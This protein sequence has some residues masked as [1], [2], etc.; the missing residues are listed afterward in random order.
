M[1]QVQN[2][3]KNLNFLELNLAKIYIMLCETIVLQANLEN[4]YEFHRKDAKTTF[5]NV[6]CNFCVFI[7]SF[8]VKKF[9]TTTINC[10]I[11]R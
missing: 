9:S 4:I 5:F 3:Q 10:N 8:Y 2:Q 7:F 11:D 1:L 6:I